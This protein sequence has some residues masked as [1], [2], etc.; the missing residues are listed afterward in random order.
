MKKTAILICGM[1]R[2]GSS[3]I[4]GSLHCGGYSI[5]HSKMAID[6]N[7]NFKGHFENQAVIDLNDKILAKSNLQWH[8]LTAS[9][10]HISKFADRAH[11]VNKIKELVLSEFKKESKIC[12][13]DP[14]LSFLIPYW[15]EALI[16]LEYD[17][18]IL[19]NIRH[20][21]EVA[22]SL[23][24][25]DFFDTEKSL[26]LFSNHVLESVLHSSNQNVK[27][28]FYEELL[29]NKDL[30]LNKILKQFELDLMT[31]SQQKA[32][33]NFVDSKLKTQKHS[34]NNTLPG[35]IKR[36]YDHI[37][38]YKDFDGTSIDTSLFKEQSEWNSLLTQILI[39]EK[40]DKKLSPYYSQLFIDTGSGFHETSS[41]ILPVDAN[42]KQLIFNLPNVDEIKNLRFDPVNDFSIIHIHSITGIQKDGNEIIFDFSGNYESTE[43]DNYYF[44]NNDPNIIFNGIDN[45]TQFKQIK[46][47]LRYVAL[48]QQVFVEKSK[49]LKEERNKLQLLKGELNFKV[50]NSLEQILLLK[51]AVSKKEEESKGQLL[52]LQSN[53]ENKLNTLNG[54][55]ISKIEELQNKHILALDALNNEIKEL[56]KDNEEFKNIIEKLTKENEVFKQ[57]N[58]GLTKEFEALTKTHKQ[59]VNDLEKEIVESNDKLSVSDGNLLGVQNQLQNLEFINKEANYKHELLVNEQKLKELDFQKTVEIKNSELKKNSEKINLLEKQSLQISEEIELKNRALIDQQNY[60]RQIDHDLKVAQQGNNILRNQIDTT[61]QEYYNVYNYTKRLNKLMALVQSSLSYKLGFLLTFPI[62]L[63]HSLVNRGKSGDS[64]LT[65]KFNKALKS[66][67]LESSIALVDGFSENATYDEISSYDELKCNFELAEIHKAHLKLKGWAISK[68]GIVRAEVLK[69]DS[70]ISSIFMGFEREDIAEIYSSHTYSLYSGFEDLVK[71]ENDINLDDKIEVR[72]LDKFGCQKTVQ[73]NPFLTNFKDKPQSVFIDTPTIAQQLPADQL[74]PIIIRLDFAR[75]ERNIVEIVGWCLF[76]HTFEKIELYI[77]DE[78]LEQ[79]SYFRTRADVGE[80]WPQYKDSVYSGFHFFDKVDFLPTPNSTIKAIAYDSNGNVAETTINLEKK[81]SDNEQYQN[82]IE[83]H[84]SKD[85]SEYT[86]ALKYFVYQPLIS[87]VIPVYNV[88]PKWLD[89]CLESITNQY[90]QNWQI[91]IHDDC[92]TKA[93]TLECLK[94]WEKTYP[95]KIKISFGKENR[96]IAGATNAAIQMATGEFVALMDNDDELTK[97]A[98]FEV[99]SALNKDK[100]LDFIYSDEDKIETDGSFVEPH[101]KSDF[102]LDML[103]ATNYISHLAAIRKSV[104]DNIGWFRDGFDG[105]Q[106]HDLYLRLIDQ[107]RKIYHIPKVLYHWRKIP[108]STSSDYEIKSNAWNASKK[109]LEDYLNRNNIIGTVEKGIWE[110]TFRIQREITDENMVSIIIPFKDKV[111]LLKVLIPSIFEKTLYSNFEILLVSNNSEKEETF[112]YVNK[113]TKENKKIQFFEYNTPFNYSEINNWAVSKTKG[114]YLLFLNNDMEVITEGWLTELLQHVQRPEVGAAGAKLLY[115]DKTVQHAGVVVGIGGV[116][117][118]IHRLIHEN[119]PGYYGRAAI[120]QNLSAC[121]GACLMVKKEAFIRSGGFDEENLK[122]AFNDIDLCL[123]IREVGYLIVYTPY[124]KLFHYESISR[125]KDD[126]LEKWNRF[127]EEVYYFQDRW[128]N[129]LNKGD[130]Y[131][132]KNLSITDTNFSINMSIPKDV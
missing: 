84:S 97:D 122:V 12:I 9:F 17:I 35:S 58:Q 102:N 117:A 101:F 88:D 82:F 60:Y 98:L 41:I 111:D 26:Y 14:R 23:K 104:G 83:I 129:V 89:I 36:L 81:L 47:N 120:T 64:S 19:I 37:L 8:S 130:E 110:G 42:D 115:K 96:K 131:Y 53:Y 67:D 86:A 114:E 126:T 77:E 119:Y 87:I 118:H 39:K 108:G 93:E 48:G 91:C 7:S 106:D 128:A 123:K 103:L 65:P 30:Y 50:Q 116:A 107:T 5:G 62:R 49:V 68:S 44:N 20:P 6:P 16:S 95:E 56:S 99:V 1:H 61:K 127:E 45:Y 57:N 105:S 79:A 90:Y 80:A 24:N 28:C 70:L 72:F 34:Q 124:T 38:E 18:K 74:D 121:T 92:S 94:K 15:S 32:I 75:V 21:Q 25:R 54:D 31:S 11:T 13:K 78:F 43:N 4:A 100:S 109:A 125:G 73:I 3:T 22:L 63:L 69:N 71:F 29:E 132:N 33:K 52:K 113:V 66:H 40:N 85:A 46:A 2:T 51:S 55:H 112:E 10:K 27:F 59:K 76:E